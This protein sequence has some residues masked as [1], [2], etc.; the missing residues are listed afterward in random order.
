MIN[1]DSLI[2]SGSEDAV[3]YCWDLIKVFKVQSKY[4]HSLLNSVFVLFYFKRERL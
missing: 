2:I 1:K 3:A 4:Y